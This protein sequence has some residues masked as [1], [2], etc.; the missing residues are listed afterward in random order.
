M[1]HTPSKLSVDVQLSFTGIV[2]FSI[3]DHEVNLHDIFT[4][5]KIIK[6]NE[7]ALTWRVNDAKVSHVD[8]EAS[9]K[10][11]EWAKKNTAVMN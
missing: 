8:S 1:L 4:E 5:R 3:E 2:F 10:F 11:C 9:Y 6:G 7:Y